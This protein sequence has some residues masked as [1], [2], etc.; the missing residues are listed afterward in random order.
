MDAPLIENMQM[1]HGTDAVALPNMADGDNSVS[2]RA[3]SPTYAPVQKAATISSRP[4]VRGKFIFVGDEKLYIRGVTYGPFAPD[5]NGNVYH[6]PEMVERDFVQIAENGINVIRVYTVPPRW[7]LD[8][9]H[10]HGLRV[11]VGLPWEQH[12]AFLDSRKRA[13]NIEESVR[14][15]VRACANHPAVL[16][17]AIGNEIPASIVR[18]YGRRRMESFLERLYRAAKDEDPESLVTYVNYPTTE[19][20]QLPFIDFVCF[21]VYLESQ[22]RLEAYIARLQNIAGDQPLVLAETGL[23]SR[24][25]GED[26]QAHTLEWQIRAAF[27]SGC[28][29]TF[30]FAWTDE[31]HRGGHDIEDWDFGLTRRDR[32]PKPAL[33]TVQN[34]FAEVPFP[35]DLDWPR[36]SVVVCTFNGASTIRDCCQGLTELEYP[37]FEVIFVNDGSNDATGNIVSEY[38]FRVITVENGGLSCARNIGMDAATGDIVAYTD[39][40]TRPDPHW[41]TYLAATFMNTEYAGVGGPNIAPT[42]DGFIADCVASAPGGPVHVLQSDQEAEHIPGCNMAFWRDCL[43]EIGGFDEQFRAAGDDVDL[44]WRIQERGWKLGFSPAAMVWHHRR[45]SFR[46]YWRQQKGYGKAEALLESKWPGKYNAAG[47]ITWNGRLYGRGLTHPISWFQERVYHG[48]WGTAPFQSLYRPPPGVLRSLPLMPEWSLIIILL[49]GVSALGVLWTPLLIALPLLL[50]AFGG[51][52]IQ[53]GLSAAQAISIVPS[54]S[55]IHG[56]KLWSLTTSLHLLQ[57]LGRL[58]GRLRNGLTMWRRQE[59][60]ASSFRF[61]RLRTSVIWSESWQAPEERLTLMEATLHNQGAVTRRGGDYDRY[62][63]EIRGGILGSVRTRMAI[64]EHGAGKQLMRFRSWPKIPLISLL[65][66]LLFGSL[67]ALTIINQEWWVFMAFSIAAGLIIIRAFG[68]C[69]SAMAAYLHAI[70]QLDMEEKKQ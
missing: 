5:E 23:D 9:A 68:D 16:C 24:T 48:T 46:A 29:G 49:L 2:E 20:L 70:E 4:C 47:H 11:M 53:A 58:Y 55:Y 33:A 32:S 56:L 63:L 52:F 64:E 41:L 66:T 57:P 14:A 3:S 51:V 34:A 30:V 38:G 36:I 69:A 15:G 42:G 18:W 1:N 35:H 60:W 40:D 44:C 31:W 19:Y 12:I 65:L 43:Q 10:S 45:N 67:S 28:A 22:D 61:P 59:T 62:D 25:H 39:D 21:N 17:Y 8:L 54:P 6:E 26:A 37:D 13:R 27:A 7:F 50:L